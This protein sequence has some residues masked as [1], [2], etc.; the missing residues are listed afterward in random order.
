[1]T[2]IDYLGKVL[3]QIGTPADEYDEGARDT[4]LHI[5][6]HLNF[7]KFEQ[8]LDHD[9]TL[10]EAKA[11]CEAH[12][13]WSPSRGGYV[14]PLQSEGTCPLYDRERSIYN[15]ALSVMPLY[16]KIDEI[17]AKLKTAKEKKE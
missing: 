10:K 3:E 5:I 2:V 9:M 4:V 17:E 1:M 8:K 16:W 12:I 13:V 7:Y 6:D 14:C 11:F 15:C